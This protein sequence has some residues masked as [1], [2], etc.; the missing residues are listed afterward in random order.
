[1]RALYKKLGPLPLIA[2]DLG[3]VTPAVRALL[4]D[5]HICGMDVMQFSHEDVRFGYHPSYKKVAYTSTHDTQTLIGW[6]KDH[7]HMDNYTAEKQAEYL[8]SEAFSSDALVSIATL[9]DVLHL[10]DSARMNVPG[11]SNDNWSWQAHTEDL[12]KSAEYVRAL[13]DQTGRI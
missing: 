5:T 4:M 2:E 7:Y 1:M 8:L 6:C 9:Q 13:V 11:T 3:I 10:D 12:A